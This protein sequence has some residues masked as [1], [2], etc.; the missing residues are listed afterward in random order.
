MKLRL[1]STNAVAAT[2]YG[3]VL[4]DTVAGTYWAANPS[5]ALILHLLEQPSTPE[6]VLSR[7]SAH[8][9]KEAAHIGEEVHALLK[10]LLDKGIIENV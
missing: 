7:T 4:L 8:F 5:A 10:D 3:S 9:G 6:D 1:K 2:D